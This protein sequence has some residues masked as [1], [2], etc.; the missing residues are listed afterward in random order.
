[1]KK[2]FAIILLL[3]LIPS[4]GISEE[5]TDDIYTFFSFRPGLNYARCLFESDLF[6]DIWGDMFFH[7]HVENDTVEDGHN[8]HTLSTIN[9][10]N[11]TGKNIQLYLRAKDT[12]LTNVIITTEKE[13]YSTDSSFSDGIGNYLNWVCSL[14]PEKYDRSRC[15]VSP[16]SDEFLIPEDE[17]GNIRIN[18]FSQFLLKFNKASITFYWKNVCGIL[19]VKREKQNT[20][21]AYIVI[22]VYENIREPE[23][24]EKE[25]VLLPIEDYKEISPFH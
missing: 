4:L 1:M 17:D 2:N 15:Y 7:N 9:P 14:F 3:I 16:C 12:I 5:E 19:E 13:K 8:I 25:L 21:S 6:G 18:D 24:W 23:Q 11:I 10:I 22:E 20:F